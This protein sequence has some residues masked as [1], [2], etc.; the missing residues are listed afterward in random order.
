MTAT[1]ILSF[2]ASVYGS[3]NYNAN[4]YNGTNAVAGG[5]TDGTTGGGLTNTGI[6]IGLIV[7]V[8]AAILLVAMIVRIW[9][10]PARKQES[11]S[12]EA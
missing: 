10:R 8:S 11:E 9:K 7:G 2:I 1:L 6:A 12:D 3:G 4:N 5:T